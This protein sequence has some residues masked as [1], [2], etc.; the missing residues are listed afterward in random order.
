MSNQI[1]R[2]T[3]GHPEPG[4]PKLLRQALSSSEATA[5]LPVAAW[6]PL[7]PASPPDPGVYKADSVTLVVCLRI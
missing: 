7:A 3:S 1:L 4:A 5:F 2:L 6:P